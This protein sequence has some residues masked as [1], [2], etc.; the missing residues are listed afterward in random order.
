MRRAELDHL[1]RADE[2]H[3]L[4][5]EPFEDAF[6]KMHGGGGHRDDVG[7]DGRGRAHFLRHR[8]GALEQLVEQ[9][10]EGAGLFGGT[11][12]LLHL[13]EDLWLAEHHRVEAGSDAEHVAHRILLRMAIEV[14]LDAARRQRV[15]LGQPVHRRGRLFGSAI[16]FHAVAGRQD[17]RLAHRPAA[18]QVVQCLRQALRVERHLL[19]NVE[20]GRMVIDAES[21]YLHGACLRM[22][23]LD[24]R[25][26]PCVRF[27]PAR[28]S[29]PLFGIT[30]H[31]GKRAI[32]R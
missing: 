9:R 31:H 27:N 1:A 10:A 16:Q 25:D 18:Q 29:F 28:S 20:R 8:E 13:A 23:Y 12:R 26:D 17:R 21:E 5:V 3:T 30:T 22:Q 6:R 15:I 7:T 4:L 11:R 14:G 19:A 24:I 32:A 2:Q